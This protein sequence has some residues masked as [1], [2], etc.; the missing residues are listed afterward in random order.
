ML[1]SRGCLRRAALLI[2]C[3]AASLPPA[4]RGGPVRVGDGTVL[5]SRLQPYDNAF[6][7]TK[8][9]KDGRID[10][11][12]IWTD[13]LRLR[14]VAG[15]RMYV[16]TQGL[17]YEDGR[18]LSSINVFDPATLM[19]LSDRQHNADGSIETWAIEGMR[20]EGR[21]RSAPN[22]REEIR[23]SVLR[24]PAFDFNCCMRSLL[25][26]A[27]PL[28]LGYSAELPAIVMG[29]GDPGSVPVQVVGRERIR[30][31]A[32][33]PVD[34]WIVETPVPGGG[35]LRFWI[36]EKPPFVIRF[37]VSAAGKRNYDQSFDMLE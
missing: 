6:V 28:R 3:A 31:G 21:I 20:V 12:G 22:S 23:R 26:A 34:T 14:E 4:P 32:R 35:E 11:P 33:G 7:V 19:P 18:M 25:I 29:D 27:L 10:H 24:E 5:G 1:L 9:Y 13:Q 15:R 37:T 17:A 36:S 2:S 30:A 16:R 8:T